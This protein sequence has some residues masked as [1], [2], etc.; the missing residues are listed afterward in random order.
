MSA[1][2]GDIRTVG[3]A[4]RGGAVVDAQSSRTVTGL[5]G[6]YLLVAGAVSLSWLIGFFE[7]SFVWAFLL[8]SA[9]FIVWKAK[10]SRIIK[11]H[12]NVEETVLYRRRA[13]RQNETVE[14]LNF[15]LNRWWVFSSFSIEQLI[16]KRLDE[17]LWD[18]K[19]QFLDNLELHTF[20]TGEQTPNVRNVQVF[21]YCEGIPGGHKPI[22]WFSIN[23]PPAGLNKMSNYQLVVQCDVQLLSEDFKMIFRARV[24]S[25]K[26]NIGFDMAVEELQVSGTMQAILHLS[27]DVPFPHITKATMSF[28]ETPD[29]TFNLR[30]MKTL[31]MMEVPLLKSWIHTNV[32]EGLTKAMVNPASVDLTL[33]KAGPVEITR[34]GRKQP[35][36]QGVLTI[37]VKGTPPKDPAAEDVRYSVLRI[38]DRKRQTHDVP[39]AEEWNDV[40]TFFIYSLAKEEI[41]IK[42]KC[43]RLLTSTTLE[44]TTVPLS[45]FP[46]QVKSFAEKTISNKDGSELHMNMQYTALPV[47]NLEAAEVEKR[48]KVTEVA[49]VMYVCI[50]GASNVK[51]ADKTGASDPYC[52]LFCNR[53]RLLTTPYV[54]VTR[55][56]RW[57]SWVEFFVGDFTQS[58]YSFFVFDWDGSSTINDDFLGVAHLSLLKE[59][60]SVVKR[61]LTLGY[62]RPEEGFTPD[63][64]CG[65]ITV[66]ILFRPVAS[67]AKSERF[68]GAEYSFKGDEY[69]Y[70]E[71]LVSPS[72]VSSSSRAH[73]PKD[74]EIPDDQ[75][76]GDTRRSLSAAH[77][78][79]EILEDKLIAEL[80]ILQGKDLV[81]MDRNG[82]SDPFCIVSMNGKKVFT[83]SVKKKTL[84]PKWNELVTLEMKE[85]GSVMTID[86]YDKDMISKDF[87][88]KVTLTPEKLKELSIKGAAEWFPLERTKTGKLQL[89]CT[90]IS[91]DTLKNSAGTLGDNDVFEPS[92]KSIPAMVIDSTH[93]AP[94]NASLPSPPR[95]GSHA[96]ALSPMG[97]VQLR[98]SSSDVN[99]DTAGS[100]ER[101]DGD[102]NT[103]TLPRRSPNRRKTPSVNSVNLPPRDHTDNVSLDEKGDSDL[104]NTTTETVDSTM[105]MSDKLFSVTG[106][107]HKARGLDAGGEDVYCKVRLEH[108]GSRVSLFSGSRVIGKSKHVPPSGALFDI[109][110]EVD[111]GHGI[112]PEATLVFDIKRSSR[113][114]LTTKSFSLREILAEAHSNRQWLMLDNGIEL[115]VS[116]TTGQ[117]TP[118][119]RRRRVLKNLSFRRDK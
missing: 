84:F 101:Q 66:S 11:Q 117:P 110:F 44:Q 37:H 61:S 50:H 116:L 9:L 24:G 3:D 97:P 67:V 105:S 20:S 94:V 88:G 52:V 106:T 69:L 49:G 111:R 78:M 80:T 60:T 93:A 113:E 79:D 56:P 70:R 53:R 90:V 73:P 65:N 47:V 103:S 75:E 14:W 15:L 102:S 8:I 118:H 27:M 112:S 19:P 76:L 83:T 31:Q 81:A 25:K 89:K 87:M 64:T 1:P 40:C 2:N 38:G 45:S 36:A 63:K 58:T 99:V 104:L 82:F 71:D 35:M 21:E 86:V 29:V 10:I 98:R 6:M 92:R 48:R 68:R 32:M 54:P 109:K 43:K 42:S 22:T 57:E 96:D 4:K 18:I 95:N 74:S 119:I 23:K 30:M 34:K 51:A 39:A 16:K 115:E 12:L 108:P 72:S 62:N 107:V 91:K 5:T 41:V 7:F 46:F 28:C 100:P 114:H 77:Y 33:A 13:F 55:N 17:R 85:E 26:V 59:E